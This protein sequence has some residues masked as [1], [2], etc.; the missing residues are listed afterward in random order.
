MCAALVRQGAAFPAPVADLA[1]D[2]QRLLVILDGLA[3]VA[4]GMVGVAEVHQCPTFMLPVLHKTRG[5]EL[6][7]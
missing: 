4:Q 1:E 7:L 5:V 2:G 3:R 6:A